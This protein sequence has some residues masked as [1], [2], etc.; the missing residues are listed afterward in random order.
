M[1]LDG[2]NQRPLT[3]QID[4]EEEPVWAPDGTEVLYR[5]TLPG[6]VVGI[7][8]ANV[9]AGEPRLVMGGE[10]RPK[11]PDLSP[12]GSMLLFNAMNRGSAEI[13]IVS[14]E[15]DEPHR[16]PDTPDWG[17]APVWSPDGQMIAFGLLD[18]SSFSARVH[19]MSVDGSRAT[20]LTAAGET[21]EYPCWSPDGERIAFQ[22][23]RDGNFEIYVM[24]S[25]G[26]GLRR[27]TND[28]AFDRRPSWR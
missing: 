8:A 4:I 10:L 27:L 9:A 1:D 20:A 18:P 5:K 13:W 11:E 3:K 25:D 7:F 2:S 17:M 15:S 22:T 26:T 24:K 16:L 21:S 23:Y 28:P 6:G 19:V 12:D 14:A